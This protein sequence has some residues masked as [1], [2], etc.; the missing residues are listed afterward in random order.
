MASDQSFVEYVCE[1]IAAAGRISQR[2]MFGEYAVYCDGKVVA[3]VC[4]NQFFLK[5]TEAGRA[6][7]PKIKE[8]VPFPGAKPW[9]IADEWLDDDV[10]V[11]RLVRVTAAAL[12]TPKMKAAKAGKSLR[13]SK[14]R[15]K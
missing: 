15:K 6:L 1:Q 9:I 12:P 13:T 7:L 4:D 10:L 11:T 5:P 3:L 2:K 8:G 14:A